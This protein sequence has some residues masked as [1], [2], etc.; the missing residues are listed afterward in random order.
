MIS[1]KKTTSTEQ[2]PVLELSTLSVTKPDV[3]DSQNRR[4]DSDTFLH[5]ASFS[6][7]L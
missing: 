5:L 6:R 1:A 3:M 7:P 2:E 4:S